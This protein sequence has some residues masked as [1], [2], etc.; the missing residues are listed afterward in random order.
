MRKR[1]QKS[2]RQFLET[3]K[4]MIQNLIFLALIFVLCGPGTLSS[5][6]QYGVPCIAMPLL[7]K[8]HTLLQS[9]HRSFIINLANYSISIYLSL[10]LSQQM[11]QNEEPFYNFPP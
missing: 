5:G 4:F 2:E 8:E 1:P 3:I 6:R 7:I 9:N 10:I 11:I